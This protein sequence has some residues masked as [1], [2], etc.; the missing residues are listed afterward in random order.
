MKQI[1]SIVFSF[2]I[3]T[4]MA[5]DTA[6]CDYFKA[7]IQQHFGTSSVPT[8]EI[9]KYQ[10][11]R[12]SAYL[13]ACSQCTEDKK[14]AKKENTK[15]VAAVEDNSFKETN[16][17]TNEALYGR[18]VTKIDNKE[19][20]LLATYQK[21]NLDMLWIAQA[22]VVIACHTKKAAKES[23]AEIDFDGWK[24]LTGRSCL[25]DRAFH[26]VQNSQFAKALEEIKKEDFAKE[27]FV[28]KEN[29]QILIGALAQQI[30]VEYQNMSVWDRAKF[31][32]GWK[33]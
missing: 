32:A 13:S 3:F 18:E 19:D 6:E 29:I 12:Y 5:D 26:K 22:A 4:I 9:N 14:E 10:Q 2:S 15:R 21:D 23:N 8:K 33:Q 31:W 20:E 24:L 1:M 11:N 17:L 28:K 30:E 25:A 7:Q 27:D 16:L